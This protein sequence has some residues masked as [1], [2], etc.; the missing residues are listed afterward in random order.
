MFT[1]QFVCLLLSLLLVGA[2]A[3]ASQAGEERALVVQGEVRSILEKETIGLNDLFRVADLASPAIAVA[4]NGVGA[5]QGRARQAGLYPNPTLE[6]EIED[7]SLEDPD[8]RTDKLKLVQPLIISGRRSGARE[9][10]EAEYDASVHELVRMRRDV[11]RQVHILWVELLHSLEADAVFEELLEVANRT[12]EIARAR[13]ELKAAPESQVTKAHLAVYELELSRGRL[14]DGREKSSSELSALL[15]GLRIPVDRLGGWVRPDPADYDLQALSAEVLEGHPAVLESRERVSAAEAALRVAKSS[16]IPDLELFIAYGRS[17]AS[18]ED[19]MEG[20]VAVPIPLFDRNQGRITE[21]RY[22]VTQAE[23]DEKSVKS[24]LTAKLAST[25]LRYSTLR[26]QLRVTQKE[27]EPAARRG[28][29]QALE[30]YRA[31][32]LSFMDLI[33]AQRTLADI[34]LRGLDLARDHG[35]AGAELMSLVGRGIYEEQGEQ[36]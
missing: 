26:E 14:E 16:R 31:G 12:L 10:A 29:E 20:G 36:R 13:F 7:L 11:F 19:F 5:A 24:Q 6:F 1:R 3:R 34:R 35:M 28:M 2:L 23:Q 4:R 22:L 8:D 18:D 21:A 32:R 30:G 33:D 25:H 15:G 9:A 27:M 17:R